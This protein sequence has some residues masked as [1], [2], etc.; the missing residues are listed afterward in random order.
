MAAARYSPAPEV[1]K[2]A[3]D[4]IPVFHAHLVENIR[5]DYVFTDKIT[6]KGNKE[7]WGTM[8]KISAL[9]A[10]L[11]SDD[12]SKKHGV[13]ESFFV[14]VISEPI[15]NKLNDKQKRALVDHELCHAKVDVDE[16]GNYKLKIVPHDMEE[17]T[18]IVKRHGLWAEDVTEIA[19]VISELQ[20]N[21]LHVVVE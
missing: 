4:L 5:I 15:W 1:A 3:A 17:F 11:A 18:E 2:I 20:E 13:T 9:N 8:R 19:K 12:N 21:P 10:Y 16:E 6:K 7:V 14:M